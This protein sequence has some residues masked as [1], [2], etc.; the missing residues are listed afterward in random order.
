MHLK[1]CTPGTTFTLFGIVYANLIPSG[2]SGTGPDA[3]FNSSSETS[4]TNSIPEHFPQMGKNAD[5]STKKIFME[6]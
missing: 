4:E 5:V 2:R 3:A 6:D 1:R